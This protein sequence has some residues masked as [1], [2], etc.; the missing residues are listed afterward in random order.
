MLFLHH[1]IQFSKVLIKKDAIIIYVSEKKKQKLMETEQLA[2]GLQSKVRGR[3][4]CWFRAC[5]PNHRTNCLSR[6][7][8]RVFTRA[9]LL[10][11]VS[12]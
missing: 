6:L 11:M 9:K 3:A 10:P 2:G 4:G 7:A 1:L 12:H 5:G 8:E